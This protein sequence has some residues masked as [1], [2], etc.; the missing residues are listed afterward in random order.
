MRKWIARITE[1]VLTA[2]LIGGCVWYYRHTPPQEKSRTSMAPEAPVVETETIAVRPVHDE[3]PA[4]G[5]TVAQESVEVTATAAEKIINVFFEDGQIV[6]KGTLLVQLDNIQELATLKQAE[7][8]VAEA[9][10]EA[11]RV[12]E[13]LA[14]RAI[15]SKDYDA[16]ITRLA[17]ARAAVELVNANLR[18]RRVEAPFDG[19]LG[20]RTVSPGHLVNPGTV[21][22]TLDDL[23]KMKVDFEVSEKHLT[24]LTAGQSF[25]AQTA[26]YPKRIFTGTILAVDPRIN[27]VTRSVQIRGILDN[28]DLALRPGMLLTID[29]NLLTREVLQ[30][31]EKAIL[32]LGETQYVYRVVDGAAVRTPV[33][34][35]TRRDGQVEVTSGLSGGEAVVVEGASKLRDGMKVQLAEQLAAVQR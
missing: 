23:S 33:T 19:M 30:L 10:R 16:Q 29:L 7:I 1:W 20:R 28:P 6:R 2:L 21:I 25:S 9:E 32:S 34:T 15:S 17:A 13:L 35:G 26:A 24:R 18:D 31:P 27:P 8:V 22:T 11:A 12:T 3:L 4:L 14:K 5:T